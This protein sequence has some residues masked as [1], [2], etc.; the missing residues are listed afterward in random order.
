MG[1][2]G[3]DLVYGDWLFFTI[4]LFARAASY[5]N[6]GQ[7]PFPDAVAALFAPQGRRV[8]VIG[9]LRTYYNYT[10]CLQTP[11]SRFVQPRLD[12]E[13]FKKIC[14]ALKSFEKN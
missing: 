3:I 14:N 6:R 4:R 8:V 2:G 12:V 11:Y 5:P 10:S 1:H 9:R 7:E 13:C